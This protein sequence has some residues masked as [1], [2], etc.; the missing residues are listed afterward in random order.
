PPLLRSLIQR[1][2]L[3]TADFILPVFVCE[4][5][6]VQRPV[7]SMPGVS[8]MSIDVALDWLK[9]R[10]GEGFGAYLVFG[11]IDRAQKDAAGSPAL[12]PDNIVCRLLRAA[13]E[14]HLPMLG[15]TD[16]CFCEYTDHGHCGPLTADQSTVDN[17]ATLPLLVE[18]AINHARA[19]A[20]LIAPS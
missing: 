16:L 17:D 8:Q 6:A 19:G 14:A 11:V 13:K 5:S 7:A 18:Q 20:D 12:D 2:R 15:I 1:I 4:G 9:A 10:A 3:S